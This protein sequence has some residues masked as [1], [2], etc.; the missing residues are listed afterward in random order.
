ML[1]ATLLMARIEGVALPFLVYD[2][3]PARVEEIPT[4]FLSADASRSE[5]NAILQR[6]GR[7]PLGPKDWARMIDT[8]FSHPLG[9][10]DPVRLHGCEPDSFGGGVPGQ[11]QALELYPI[12]QEE[13][14]PEDRGRWRSYIF[15]GRGG[16]EVELGPG[17][18][19]V[20]NPIGPS[21]DSCITFPAIDGDEDQGKAR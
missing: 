21:P 5:W 20:V 1:F 4:K 18:A 6:G 10:V 12:P 2:A 19:L 16:G 11:K 8:P 15:V 7:L 17:L 13:L 9:V 14:L 3:Y